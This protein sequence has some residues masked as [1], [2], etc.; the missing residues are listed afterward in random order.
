MTLH[1]SGSLALLVL[2]CL[3]ALEDPPTPTAVGLGGVARAAPV[4]QR[5]EADTQLPD[6]SGQ[7]ETVGVTVNPTGLID[8]S[9]DDVLRV[10]RD[11]GPPP[12]KPEIRG[13][14]EQVSARFREDNEAEENSGRVTRPQA[15]LCTWGFPQLMIEAPLMFEVLPT[16]AETVMIFSGR[17]IRHI[18]TDGR[19]HTP[20]E[21]LWPTY[22][23][24]SIGHWEGRTLVID[25]IT[26]ASALNVMNGDIPVLAWG[27]GNHRGLAL[28]ALLSSQAHFLERFR[29]L[30]KDR[31]EDQLTIIDPIRFSAPWRFSRTYRRVQ[32][33]HRMVHEDCSGE[34][35]NPVVDGRFSIAPPPAP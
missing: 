22:W 9:L 34:D 5:T 19:S 16:P 20:T 2:C 30:D 35:R 1:R 11:W 7:W 33:L 14:M 17:E 18:Y 8:E 23:G 26:V 12:Y 29:M 28:V 10:A 24:D 15:P 21:D 3:S 4:R 31:L 6:W 25:T 27:G 32:R 13:A